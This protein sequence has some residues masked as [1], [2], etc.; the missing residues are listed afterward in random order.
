MSITE[1]AK[2]FFE[3]CEVGKGWDGCKAYCK[4]NATFSAQAEPLAEL[5]TL[6]EY[7]D[8]MMGALTFLPDG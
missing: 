4:P 6:Q 7:T 2:Q 8:W 3:A 1:T 5:K